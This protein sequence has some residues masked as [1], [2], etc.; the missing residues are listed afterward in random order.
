MT[1]ASKS[2]QYA[3]RPPAQVLAAEVVDLFCNLGRALFDPYRPERHYMR[4][5]GPK[6]RASQARL[7]R[8]CGATGGTGVPF[9][10]A[11]RW[12]ET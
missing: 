5:P 7:S 12:G 4:G 1:A 6:W 8:T 10:H 9:S 11:H 2:A 3:T